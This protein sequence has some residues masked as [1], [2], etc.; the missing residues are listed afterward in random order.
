[1]DWER[2][3]FGL[4]GVTEGAIVVA[5]IGFNWGGLGDRRFGYG[6]RT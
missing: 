6:R 1:M 5:V 3:R 4:L 2:I